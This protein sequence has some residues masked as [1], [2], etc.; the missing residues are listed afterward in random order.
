MRSFFQQLATEGA[1]INAERGRFDLTEK[2]FNDV[3]SDLSKVVTFSTATLNAAEMLNQLEDKFKLP[4]TTT[5]T[6][7]KRLQGELIGLELQ[8]MSTGTALAMALRQEGL[9]LRPLKPKGGQLQLHVMLYDASIDTWPVGWKSPASKKKLAPKMFDSL[10]IEIA[11]YTLE[12]ALE[13]I[14]PRIGVPL[15]LDQWILGQLQIDPSKIDVKLSRHKTFLKAALDRVLNQARL[16]GELRVDELG[17]PFYWVTQ[18]G[19]NSLRA[20]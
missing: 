17:T 15:I 12:Q 9:A 6:A 13:A 1:E 20:E 8:N 3:H 7:L 5:A 4:V 10:N 11:N 18:F 14:V 16:I 2:Q 19:K